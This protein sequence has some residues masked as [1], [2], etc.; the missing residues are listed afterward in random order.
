M[1]DALN[2]FKD[3]KIA[4]C[5]IDGTLGLGTNTF[6]GAPEFI[7]ELRRRN[8]KTYILSNNSSKSKKDYVTKLENMGFS[9]TK[10]DILLSTDSLVAYF[11]KAEIDRAYIVGTPSMIEEMES[12]GIANDENANVLALGYDTTLDYGKITQ[13]AHMLQRGAKYYVTHPDDVCPHPDGPLPDAGSFIAMFEKATGRLPDRI[14]GKPTVQMIDHVIE[15]HKARPDQCFMVGDRL[16][17]DFQ[18][19]I[20]AGIDFICVLS[21]EADRKAIEDFGHTPAL[22]VESVGHIFT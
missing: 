21:G 14:F 9:F 17:T 1:Q 7:G 20:N 15:R 2:F 19:S 10:D 13:A 6:D 3:R 22:V 16:Y 11:R 8:I 12:Q 18:M 4:F 5:D